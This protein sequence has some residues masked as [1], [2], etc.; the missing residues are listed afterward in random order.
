MSISFALEY[1]D[2]VVPE[3][4]LRKRRRRVWWHWVPM[5]Y[6]MAAGALW[7]ACAAYGTAFVSPFWLAALVPV[8]PQFLLLIVT[9]FPQAHS[10][11]NDF[12]S[13]EEF[14]TCQELQRQYSVELHDDGLIL[15]QPHVTKCLYWNSM[16]DAVRTATTLAICMS[17]SRMLPIPLRAF[18]GEA[19][20][21]EFEAAIRER[22]GVPSQPD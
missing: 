17:D 9:V 18:A 6:L 22:I 20:I 14:E 19:E 11:R 3:P 7:C 12:R 1:E 5:R 21:R 15:Q 16:V 8:P 2:F 13:R 10:P 4:I